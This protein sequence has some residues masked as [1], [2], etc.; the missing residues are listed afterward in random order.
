MQAFK[1][2]SNRSWEISLTLGSA[3]RV[4][5]LLDFD[6]LQP[7]AGDPPMITRL[8]QD[9]VLLCDVIFC[10]VKPQADAAEITDEQFG[11][12]LGGDVILAAQTALYEEM[13]FFFRHRGRQD[14]VTAVAATQRMIG[15]AVKAADQKIQELDLEA[16]VT[17]I[18]GESFTKSPEPSDSTPAV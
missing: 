13:M 16:K 5:Q 8:G 11:E 14:R 18:F 12:L 6:L 17:E 2:G 10:L 9:E 3:K 15:L 7:E 1:D 4:K